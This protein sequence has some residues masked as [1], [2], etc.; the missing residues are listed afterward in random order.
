MH[1]FLL[2]NNP[3]AP[4]SSGIWLI[5]LIKPISIIEVVKD[6]QKIHSKAAVFFQ[7]FEFK[8]PIST[9]KFQLRLYHYFTTNL[10][11]SIDN[12]ILCKNLLNE[13]WNWY[14]AYLINQKKINQI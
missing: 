10:D 2:A 14:K 11:E 9:T 7:E 8:G 1:K 3:L 13:S 6:G 12:E 5:H 4:D